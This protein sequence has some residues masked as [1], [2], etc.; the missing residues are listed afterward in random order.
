MSAKVQTQERPAAVHATTADSEESSG[1]LLQPGLS[2]E[3]EGAEK[4]SA[5]HDR[6][7]SHSHLE[8]ITSDPGH[9]HMAAVL[10]ISE[11]PSAESSS[12]S[13]C[14]QQAD[15]LFENSLAGELSKEPPYTHEEAIENILRRWLIEGEYQRDYISCR[16]F[17]KI[18]EENW[19]PS[20]E[21]EYWAVEVSF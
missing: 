14:A 3:A 5:P 4:S 6:Q 9:D 16:G 13:Q 10:H 15:A 17:S 1:E 21:F 20:H 8:L 7:R 11:N 2:P 12:G 18:P 19:C